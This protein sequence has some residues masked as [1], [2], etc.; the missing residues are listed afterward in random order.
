VTRRAI[1][2]TRVSSDKTNQHASVEQQET[3][4]RDVCKREGWTVAQVLQ[5][6]D[7]GASR[8]SSS[9]RPAYDKLAA[10]LRSGDVLVTWEASR[11][12]RDLQAYLALRELCALRGVL[13]SYS[14]RTYDLNEGDDRFTTGLDALLA[15]KEVELTRGRVLRA[16][17]AAAAQGKPHGRAPYGY[18]AQRN[19]ITRDP[20]FAVDPVEGPVVREIVERF[21]GG[22][23][24]SAITR[25]LNERH[26]PTRAGTPWHVQN[27]RRMVVRPVYIGKR[28]HRGSVVAQGTWPAL[29]TEEEQLR[30]KGMGDDPALVL[31]RGV[32]PKY[33]LS[34][35]AVCGVCGTPVV[36]YKSHSHGKPGSAYRCPKNFCV[37]RKL[38]NVDEPV[39]EYMLSLLEDPRLRE[40]LDARDDS[41][42]AAARHAREAIEE[43]LAEYEQAAIDGSISA[44]AFARIE[45][46]LNAKL[47]DLDSV[48]HQYISPLLMKI[49]GVDA[50]EIWDGLDIID[51]RT[52]VRASVS[53]KI[54][55]LRGDAQPVE[56]DWLSY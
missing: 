29:L 14:G 9:K 32:G 31:P 48:E 7:A 20:E 17:N 34:G 55:R 8:W 42:I 38:E 19:P 35:I 47:E 11:A 53:V 39:I 33:L 40:R 54:N 22:E 44:K 6:N 36:R 43:Q 4:C 30:I 23:N 15:E 41:D 52:I 50:R 26:I 51:R 10:V 27:L 56:I 37:V 16:L 46:G 24:W 3:I 5:D 45:A 28:T 25:S 49:A 2:Y 21:L 13:W 18:V 1:I 12:Q